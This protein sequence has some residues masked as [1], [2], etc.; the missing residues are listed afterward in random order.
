MKIHGEHRLILVFILLVLF[1][2]PAIGVTPQRKFLVANASGEGTIKFG[3]EEFKLHSV[4]VKLFADG[5]AEINLV[6]DITVFITGK[7]TKSADPKT[8]DLEIT[9]TVTEGR[10]DGGGKLLLTNDRK[11]IAG[12]NLE[13][14]NKFTKNKITIDFTAK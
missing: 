13:V 4:V 1:V 12:L 6:T 9:G 14:V 7:W 11:S 8:I 10:L 3:Q 2:F 5:K